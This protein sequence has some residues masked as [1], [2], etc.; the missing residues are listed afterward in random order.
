MHY[1][2]YRK[3]GA[4]VDLGKLRGKPRLDL[5]YYAFGVPEPGKTMLEG[6]E[7][8]GV[9]LP[10]PTNHVGKGDDALASELHALVE[11]TVKQT[12]IE[13]VSLSGGLDSA[14]VA[15]VAKPKVVFSCRYADYDELGYAKAVAEKIGA[16][17]VIVE[18]TEVDARESL[19]AIV[20]AVGQ[21]IFPSSAVGCWKL[22]DAMQK[23]GIRSAAD[24]T[25]P[26]ECFG[27]YVRYLL[28]VAEHTLVNCP[29]LRNY[30]GMLT[31]F[32]GPT[33]DPGG[34][35]TP[36]RYFNLLRSGG[37]ADS[38]AYKFVWQQFAYSWGLVEAMTRV[39]LQLG[40]RGF[41]GMTSGCARAHGIEWHSPLFT[42]EIVAFG[43]G[44]P[45]H[46]K[47]DP[48]AALDG[49]PATKV[50]M[51]RVARE[52]G[53]PEQI[54]NRTD[55]Q[56]W[57]TPIARWFDGPLASWVHELRTSLS[58]R[59]YALRS[60]PSRGAFDQ[61]TFADVCLELWLRRVS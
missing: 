14:I 41:V 49:R 20:E 15:M 26:D 50:L 47:T 34:A 8:V 54:L 51:R 40:M 2:D 12:P 1:G 23:H 6:V 56:G 48:V 46:L 11:A 3:D 19:P 5:F 16:K 59:G 57:V 39:D 42:D 17:H 13:A 61:S 58:S 18:P 43:L 53:V 27:G 4:K 52:F 60:D 33:S 10:T 30:Q 9:M 45:D 32:W 37:E 25:G 28:I 7:E 31:R 22:A 36:R 44:L 55:K 35:R 29:E 38:P 24:G 21:P